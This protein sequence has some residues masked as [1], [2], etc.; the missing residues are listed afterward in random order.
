MRLLG[1]FLLTAALAAEAPNLVRNGD[2]ESWDAPKTQTAPKDTP[3]LPDGAPVDWR[4]WQEAY[5]RGE[6]PDY[7]IRGTLARD[8]AV[9]HGGAAAVRFENALTTDI[10]ELRQPLTGIRPNTVYRVVVWLKGEGI[11]LN[12]RDGCGPIVWAVPGTGDATARVPIRRDGTFDWTRFEFEVETGPGIDRLA[13]VLQLRRASGKLWY[14]DVAVHK[15]AEVRRVE[16]Y[17]AKPAYSAANSSPIA[18]STASTITCP[19]A[20]ETRQLAGTAP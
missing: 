8:T 19:P 18:S 20:G 16:S 5:E 12:A 4:P 6:Q 1:L 11:R 10:S 9:H 2:F 7:A 3:A 13:L 15:L 14:D 17:C